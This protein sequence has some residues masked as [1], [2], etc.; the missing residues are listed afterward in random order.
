MSEPAPTRAEPDDG[1]NPS[2]PDISRPVS[3][4]SVGVIPW[5]VFVILVIVIA[6]FVRL[7][8][9][10][11]DISLMIAI[12]AVGGFACAEVGRRIPV[13][14]A[15]GAAAIF[16]T[17][18]PSYLAYAHVLPANMLVAVKTFTKDSQFLFLYIAAIVVGSVLSMDREVLVRGFLVIFAPIVAGTLAAIAVGM[19]VGTALGIGAHD[20]FFFVLMPALGG[21]VG[22]GAIPLSIGYA[23]LVH[24]DS[25]LLLARILPAVMFASL[26]AIVFCGILNYVGRSRPGLTGYG[27]LQIGA[28]DAIGALN[29]APGMVIGAPEVAAAGICAVALYLVG[30]LIQNLAGFPGPITMLLLAIALNLLRWV[31]PTLKAGAYAYYKFFSSAVTYPLLFAIG[32]SLTPWDKL[33]AAFTP[34]MVI[35]IVATVA[36]LMATGFFVGRALRMYPIEA[37]IVTGCRASQGGT[38]DVAI[39]T[40][41]DRLQLMP[42][43]QIATRIGGAMTVIVAL[44][45]MRI[46][47]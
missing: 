31:S 12:L 26:T 28:H 19:A 38:G 44:S 3:G 7:G 16:A 23:A 33:I 42:F 18:I 1:A 13:I 2:R 43:A 5:P 32:V 11:S 27:T 20:T 35:T 22:E 21:G 40:A 15:V 30:L 8:K 25:G 39:L 41:C 10:P 37:A 14:R 4:Y 17:F 45:L 34:A 29:A 6:M 36:T 24:Q 46:Y 47:G 9:L